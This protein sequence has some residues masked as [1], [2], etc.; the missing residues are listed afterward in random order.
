MIPCPV[1]AGPP[2]VSM[3]CWNLDLSLTA[4]KCTTRTSFVWPMLRGVGG[5]GSRIKLYP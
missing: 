5:T 1:A 4:S 3:T 2:Y